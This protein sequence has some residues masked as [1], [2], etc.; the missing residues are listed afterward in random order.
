M[1]RAYLEM[2][3]AVLLFGFTAILGDLIQLPAIS[4]VWWRVLL[5]CLSICFLIPIVME[6]RQLG[7]RTILQF[8]GIGVLVGLHWI[9]FYGS[10]KLANASIAL[11]C[12][13]VTALFTSVLEPLFFRRRLN[14]YELL[15]GIAVIPG[16]ML[17]V[18]S[19]QTDM[20]LGVWVGLLSAFLAST[21]AILNKKMVKAAR[22]FT[23]TFLELGSACLF[24]SVLLPFYFQIDETATF[25]PPDWT[26]WVY[27]VLLALLCT[28]LAYSLSLRALEHLSAF[29]SNLSLNLEPVYGILMA[30]L[31]L[32]EHEELSPNF[33]YGVAV[34]LLA[35]LS[36]P[37][38]QKIKT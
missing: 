32:N 21:F 13:A 10:I 29:A 9:C 31:I 5:T 20:L 6:I 23:I 12:M 33:Y 19:I 35:V 18:N 3:L 22:P 38:L 1:T 14:W 16:M 17:I 27:L 34:I 28:T 7:R 26:D 37:L 2:H 8:M 30:W 24:I 15:L 11:I 4:L 25:L 36:Y